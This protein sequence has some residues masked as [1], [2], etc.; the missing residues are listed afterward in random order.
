[1]SAASDADD[2]PAAGGAP[3]GNAVMLT[4][5]IVNKLGLHSRP[6][7]KFAAMAET[8]DAAVLVSARGGEPIDG[9]SILDLLMLGAG[10]GSILSIEATGPEAGAAVDALASLV[11]SGFGEGE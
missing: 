1:M 11:E 8:F 3:R 6:A 4:V 9:S 7:A 10:Q 5:E 2:G